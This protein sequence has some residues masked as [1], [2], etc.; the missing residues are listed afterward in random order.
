MV[1]IFPWLKSELT[2]PRHSFFN[3]ILSTCPDSVDEILL[4]SNGDWH[5]EDG[6]YASPGWKAANPMGPPP[7]ARLLAGSKGPSRTATPEVKLQQD[8]PAQPPTSKLA[9]DEVATPPQAS[10]SHE[11][12]ELSDSDDDIVIPASRVI[13]RPPSTPPKRFSELESAISVSPSTARLIN[14]GFDADNAIAI[15]DSDDDEPIAT[16][17]TNAK[18]TQNGQHTNGFA[19]NGTNGTTS[20]NVSRKRPR[21]S[22]EKDGAGMDKRRRTVSSSDNSGWTNSS[23]LSGFGQGSTGYGSNGDEHY[24]HSSDYSSPLLP[25]RAQPKQS[26]SSYGPNDNHLENDPLQGSERASNDNFRYP[27]YSGT[28]GNSTSYTGED[29]GSSSARPVS[30]QGNTRTSFSSLP[31]YSSYTSG[32]RPQVPMSSSYSKP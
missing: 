29:G 5:T 6:K 28:T 12:V 11:V 7:S 27:G 22:P 26:D 30:A 24:S 16:T 18:H 25:P 20:T 8:S 4:E 23:P 1:L 21:S 32:S 19:D 2:F 3:S 9:T 15:D 13:R 31:I 10:A 17:S 14:L